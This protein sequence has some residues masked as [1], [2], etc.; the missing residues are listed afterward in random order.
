MFRMRLM[1]TGVVPM[2]GWDTYRCGRGGMAG[3]LLGVYPV[4][5]GSGTPFDIGEL[6]TYLNDAVLLSPGMLLAWT[7]AGSPSMTTDS[8]FSYTMPAEQ[9]RLWCRSTT[10]ARRS[11]SRPRTGSWTGPTDRCRPPGPPQSMG[12]RSCK[13]TTGCSRRPPR[14]GI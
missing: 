7:P 2:T 13:A 5:T 9:S 14:N 3:K 10:A 4:A 8:A 1:F 11:T 6:T 12:G